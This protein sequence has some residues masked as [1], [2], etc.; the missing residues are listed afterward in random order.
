M[1]LVVACVLVLLVACAGAASDA[2]AGSLAA[3]PCRLI[4]EREVSRILRALISTSAA[5]R[6][7]SS[8]GTASLAAAL[9]ALHVGAG[10]ARGSSCRAADLDGV[11]LAL[12][13]QSH[14][15][16]QER[17]RRHE[18]QSPHVLGASAAGSQ[19]L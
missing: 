19:C 5:R 6:A 1:R 18:C 2:R 17:V 7:E 12:G 14:R 8:A 3:H 9:D 4:S 11:R 13:L 15:E 10:A 16:R